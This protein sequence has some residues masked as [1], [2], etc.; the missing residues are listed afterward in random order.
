[1]FRIEESAVDISDCNRHFK[2]KRRLLASQETSWQQ[3]GMQED[4]KSALFMKKGAISKSNI[5]MNL[6]ESLI[7][8]PTDSGPVE[9][10]SRPP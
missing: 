3:I 9:P 1:M 4:L 8:D 6:M 5:Y 10:S 7:L 2:T